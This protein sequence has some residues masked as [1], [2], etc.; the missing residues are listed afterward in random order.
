M[1]LEDSEASF[2]HGL[3]V[4]FDIWNNFSNY[5]HDDFSKFPLEIITI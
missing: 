1:D 5:R 4:H 3:C 2:F